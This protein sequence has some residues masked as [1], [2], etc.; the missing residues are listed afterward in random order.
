MRILKDTHVNF[1]QFTKATAIFSVVFIL[2]SLISVFGLR[3][4][5]YGIDFSGGTLVQ[6]K[7]END[8]T[9]GEIRSDLAEVG[10]DKSVIQQLG[11]ENE[12]LI[13]VGEHGSDVNAQELVESTLQKRDNSYELLKV[14][15]VGPQIGAELR[16]TAVKAILWAIVVIAVYIS[17]RFEFRFAIGAVIALIHDVL[18]T[19][20]IF[21]FLQ[22]EI[23][24]STIAA[25]LTIVGYS[26]NDT[27]VL[28]DRVRENRKKNKRLDIS[29]LVNN[30]INQTISR[31]IITSL[32]TLVVVI[33]LAFSKGEIQI[34]AFTMIIGVIVGTYS[35]IFIA[36]PVVVEWEKRLQKQK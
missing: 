21:S 28:Y 5:N 30:S 11:G 26:L 3:G 35:S 1:L 29:T 33:V 27:I 4:L 34:F 16:K 22:F 13:R 7:F 20:G 31:T 6:L 18:F 14:D 9:S 17:F 24:V 2:V 12:F 32:T 10:L 36:G 8:I 15:K 23:S 19:L 25:F